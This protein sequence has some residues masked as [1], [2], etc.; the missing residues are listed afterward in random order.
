MDL[1]KEALAVGTG[2]VP[3][4]ARRFAAVLMPEGL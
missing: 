1:L 3:L 4:R 2:P